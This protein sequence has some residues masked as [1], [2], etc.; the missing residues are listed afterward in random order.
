MFS[1]ERFTRHLYRA[2][3]AP[4]AR[5]VASSG[6]VCEAEIGVGTRV[7][8]AVCAVGGR[9]C[10]PAVRGLCRDLVRAPWCRDVTTHVGSECSAPILYVDGPARTPWHRL[11]LGA[12][13]AG[14]ASRLCARQGAPV[15]PPPGAAARH[16]ASGNTV[17]SI[18]RSGRLVSIPDHAGQTLADMCVCGRKRLSSNIV[19]FM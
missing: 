18:T 1:A 13:R 15:P 17:Y 6:R 8:S 10:R 12:G 5:A 19:R 3:C 14:A 2:S 9:R 11:W 16:P 4:R 7:P